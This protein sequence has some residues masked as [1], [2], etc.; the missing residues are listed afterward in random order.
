MKKEESRITEF[1]THN[2]LYLNP[3]SFIDHFCHCPV[4]DMNEMNGNIHTVCGA[5]RKEKINI[6]EKKKK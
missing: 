1:K 6:K 2:E 5:E 3:D 4:I